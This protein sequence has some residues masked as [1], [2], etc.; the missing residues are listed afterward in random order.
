[1]DSFGASKGGGTG[2]AEGLKPH[3]CFK[4]L[5]QLA[6]FQAHLPKSVTSNTM[7]PSICIDSQLSESKSTS[8]NSSLQK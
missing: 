6:K 1:M 4:D 7:T 5:N 2:G 8:L 3:Q